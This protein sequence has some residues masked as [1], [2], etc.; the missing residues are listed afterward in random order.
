MKSILFGLI[1][2]LTMGVLSGCDFDDTIMP[3]ADV[4][5]TSDRYWVGYTCANAFALEVIY[6][7]RDQGEPTAAFFITGELTEAQIN[8]GVMSLLPSASGAKY[9]DGKY[10]WWTKGNEAFLADASDAENMILSDC[11]E[12]P[13]IEG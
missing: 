1:T 6:D 13:S 11:V 7:N 9:S 5:V 8:P 4:D 2:V 12:V 3:K 10:V